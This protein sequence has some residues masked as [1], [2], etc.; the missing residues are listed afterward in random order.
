M[1]NLETF[2]LEFVECKSVAILALAI[3][4]V[5][6]V[7]SGPRPRSILFSVNY[8][9][10]KYIMGKKQNRARASVKKDSHSPKALAMPSVKEIGSLFERVIFLSLADAPP[11]SA[12]SHLMITECNRVQEKGSE[13]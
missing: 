11:V 7:D 12:E 2:F 1:C 8:V 10:D 13:Q 3:A 5:P 6:R 4:C 9:C